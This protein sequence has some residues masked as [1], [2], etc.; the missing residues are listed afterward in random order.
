VPAMHACGCNTWYSAQ[1][2][3]RGCRPQPIGRGGKCG[4]LKNAHVLRTIC[5]RGKSNLGTTDLDSKTLQSARLDELAKKSCPGVESCGKGQ[6]LRADWRGAGGWSIVGKRGTVEHVQSGSRRVSEALGG[7]IWCWETVIWGRPAVLCLGALL[8]DRG[9][10][11]RRPVRGKTWTWVGRCKDSPLRLG[12]ARWPH[13]LAVSLALSQL[14]CHC[15]V[16]PSCSASSRRRSASHLPVS[17]PVQPLKR[18][19]L[20]SGRRPP[21]ALQQRPRISCPRSAACPSD[22]LLAPL[23]SARRRRPDPR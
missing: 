11:D 12:S 3:L 17:V 10:M 18:Q 5:M 9:R 4:A 13:S 23:S 22:A 15:H 6:R 21:D 7:R 1:H 14:H 2:P 20:R 19:A 16:P 8:R